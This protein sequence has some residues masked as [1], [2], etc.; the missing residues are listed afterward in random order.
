MSK[1]DLPVGSVAIVGA[2]GTEGREELRA[3]LDA[4]QACS[5]LALHN[6]SLE[7]PPLP[8]QNHHVVRNS[9]LNDPRGQCAGLEGAL[10][11]PQHPNACPA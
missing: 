4:E 2:D 5:G 8:L 10:R 9:F 7:A 1:V 3:L 6:I 11:G